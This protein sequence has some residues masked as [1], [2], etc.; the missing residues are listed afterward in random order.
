MLKRFA[1]LD[2]PRL[3]RIGKEFAKDAYYM[4]H[5]L[6]G[7]GADAMAW[8]MTDEQLKQRAEIHNIEIPVAFADA[9]MVLLLS[10]PRSGAKR[11]RRPLWSV[12]E[13]R[14]LTDSGAASKRKVAKM[15]SERTGRDAENIRRRLRGRKA[16]KKTPGDN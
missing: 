13:A 9:L 5:D 12:D 3:L 7:Y 6:E 10:L 2:D 4:A 11:G 1:Y 15:I 16:A 8:L 14:K